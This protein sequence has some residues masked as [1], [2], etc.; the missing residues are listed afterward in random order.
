MISEQQLEDF[1]WFT[2]NYQSL[3]GKYGNCFL[4]IK[5]REVL[6]SYPSYAEA[7]KESGSK[8]DL[9]TFIVQQCN[10]QESAYMSYNVTSYSC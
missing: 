10:G 3:Y 6:G 8:Y 7:V 2:E 1:N 4:S 9:G 5:N